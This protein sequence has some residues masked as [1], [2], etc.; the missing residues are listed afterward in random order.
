M[1]GKLTWEIEGNNSFEESGT[2][3][4][5]LGRLTQLF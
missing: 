2:G 5:L 1:Y 3:K 4:T